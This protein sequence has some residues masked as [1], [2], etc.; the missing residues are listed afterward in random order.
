MLKSKPKRWNIFKPIEIH[1]SLLAT[2]QILYK[3][4]LQKKYLGKPELFKI[5][6]TVCTY[7]NEAKRHLGR[8]KFVCTVCF[9]KVLYKSTGFERFAKLKL[10]M[11]C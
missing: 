11:E 8:T 5:N 10:R 4:I 6:K 3:A 2:S 9:R 7:K 1:F